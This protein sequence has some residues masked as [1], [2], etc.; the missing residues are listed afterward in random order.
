[1]HSAALDLNWYQYFLLDVIVMLALGLCLVVIVIF[2]VFRAVATN[3]FSNMS[4]SNVH[5]P[6]NK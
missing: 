1:M 5:V 4:D 2:F 6:K 3:I